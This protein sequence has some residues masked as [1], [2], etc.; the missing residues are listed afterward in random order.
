MQL[1]REFFTPESMITLA[2][3]AGA[4]FVVCNSLQKAFN[5]NPRWLALVVAQAIVLTGTGASGGTRVIDYLVG[6]INGFLVFLTA[7]GGTG[8]AAGGG[9]IP[10]VARGAA[11]SATTTA[12][13]RR[14]FATPW[15]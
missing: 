13:N 11:A 1:P 9:G 15:F 4:T 7:A 10:A 2:G 6:I 14:T 5:F 12:S 8:A 3:A